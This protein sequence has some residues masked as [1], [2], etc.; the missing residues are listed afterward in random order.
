MKKHAFTM[1]EILATV[2]II[3]I[4]AA[5]AMAFFR[6]DFNHQKTC[7]Y[8]L[9]TI[10]N[11]IEEYRDAT[12]AYPS[13]AAGGLKAA[14]YSAYVSDEKIFTCPSDQSG[15]DSYSLFYVKPN[16]YSAMDTLVVG[17]PRHESNKKAMDLFF[18]G[19]VIKHNLA[20]VTCGGSP[21]APGDTVTGTVNFAD[22]TQATVSNGS[23]IMIQSFYIGNGRCYSIL[24]ATTPGTIIISDVIEGSRYE[25]IT[26]TAVA[27]VG[28]T[29]FMITVS[30]TDTYVGVADGKVTC[31]ERTGSGREEINAGSAAHVEH[32]KRP[33]RMAVDDPDLPANVKNY[34]K[35]HKKG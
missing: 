2:I 15:Q 12:G 3:G 24:K 8:N 21:V 26:P 31:Y 33:K 13:D 9:R 32:N 30:D 1:I 25:I 4:I 16:D 18:Q 35:K 5:T 29:Q 28:G 20:P 22:G 6:G 27:G 10:Y 23:A 14:L 11:A 34:L 7:A 17:C 19:Q